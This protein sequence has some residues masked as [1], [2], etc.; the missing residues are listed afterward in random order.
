MLQINT[1]IWNVCQSGFWLKMT[2]CFLT[3]RLLDA[4][5]WFPAWDPLFGVCTLVST[6]LDVD[7]L[8]HIRQKEAIRQKHS[9]PKAFLKERLCWVIC[10]PEMDHGLGHDPW[11]TNNRVRWRRQ[12]VCRP[13]FDRHFY[14]WYFWEERC[15]LFWKNWHQLQ[16]RRWDEVKAGHFYT[17]NTACEEETFTTSDHL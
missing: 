6:V 2:I 5:A 3:P 16:R 12:L 11:N 1:H 10:W 4:R 15:K 13:G 8:P 7:C 14:K 9:Q 17:R